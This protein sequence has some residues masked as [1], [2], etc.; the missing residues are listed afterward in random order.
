L[1]QR[2][3]PQKRQRL[4]PEIHRQ[5]A[6][7]RS[8]ARSNLQR[9]VPCTRAEVNDGAARSDIQLTKDVVGALPRIALALDRIERAQ[10]RGGLSG[11]IHE[12]RRGNERN[13]ASEAPHH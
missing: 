9:E 13:H 2:A 3:H 8:H 10:G 5:H 6:T 4:A 11:N 12:R 7:A 1:K